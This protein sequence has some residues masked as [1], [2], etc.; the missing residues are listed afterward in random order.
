MIRGLIFERRLPVVHV[1]R[2]VRIDER[3]LEAFIAANRSDAAS[4]IREVGR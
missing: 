2:L 3:D 1:G 4:R